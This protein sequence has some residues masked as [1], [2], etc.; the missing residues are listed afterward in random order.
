MQKRFLFLTLFFFTG[1]C[2]AQVSVKL[3]QPPPN[4]LSVTDIWKLTLINSGKNSIQITLNGTLEEAGDGII[5][6]GNSKPISLP[7]G[8]KRITY[9][10]IKTGNVNFKSG[11]WR[12]AFTRTGNAP[13]GD[14]TICIRVKS[15]SGEEI[16][17]DCINQKV[18]ISSPPT[19][20]SPVDG[21]SIPA[22]KPPTFTWLPPMPA[23]SGQMT[24]KLKIVE[25]I[26]NQS[27][28]TAIQRNSAWFE[29]SEIRTTMF[30]Y[31]VSARKFET[32][33]K[34]AWQIF[35]AQN[36]SSITS[37][38]IRR[39]DFQ[40][41]NNNLKSLIITT[42]DSTGSSGSSNTQL[43]A[44]GCQS[45]PQAA[46]ITNQIP[47]SKVANDFVQQII[48]VGLFSMKVLAAS[49]NSSALTGTGSILVPWLKTP[50]AVEF[51]N[52]KVNTVDELYD[53]N[54]ITQFDQTPDTWP[55]QWL[56]N[57]AGSFNWTTAKVKKL[58]HWLH[59]T[60]S[61]YP[62]VNKLVKDF[63]L[64]QM[65]QD[66]T[67]TP[68]KLPLGINNAD[69]YTIA[70]SEMKFEPTS[71]KLNCLAIFPVNEY[72]DSVGFK[73]S[74]IIFST[75]G[76]SLQSGKLGLIDDATFI[77]N[78]P[79]GD[80]YTVLIKKEQGASNGTFIS[81]DCEGFRELNIDLDVMFPRSWLKPVPDNGTDKAK[82]NI[83]TNI[84][85]WDDWI[86]AANLPKCT[87][88]GTQGM[89][90][91]VTSF[92]YDHSNLRNPDSLSFPANYPAGA[93]TGVSFTGFFIKEAK[94]KFP[95][96][97]KTSTQNITV[98]I[99]NMIINKQG[100]TGKVLAKDI[101]TFPNGNIS[102]LGASLDTL[103][104][105]IVC[106]SLTNAYLRGK[107]VLPV[108]EVNPLNS[109]PFKATF[110]ANN[111]FLF[112]IK[113]QGPITAKF[114][115]DA[116]LVLANTSTIN[117]SINN[118]TKFD[119]NLNG[120]FEWANINIGPVKNVKMAMDFQNVGLSYMDSTN[121]HNFTFNI[122][123]WSF[124]SPPK[125]LANFPVSI[126][127][128]KFK[129]KPKQGTE[130]I[131][132]GVSF[133]IIV[134][135][136]E[137]IG[138]TC[139]LSVIGAIEKDAV[140]GKFT[141]TFVGV[142]LD[143]IKVFANLSAVKLDGKI[144][145]Y[146]ADPVYG[147]G[148]MG[149]I[150]ATINSIK[151]EISSTLRMGS[152]NYNNGS[153]F[154]RYW[155]VDAKVILPK[156][157]GIPFMSGLAFYGFG[158]GVWRRMTVLN[159]PP[160]NP[161]D[162]ENAATTT[163]TTNSGA[164]FTPDKNIGLGLSVLAVIGTYPEPKAFNSDA[165]LTGEFSLAG[166]LNMIKFN[167]DFWCMA[168]LT[169]RSDATILGNAYV[170][171]VPPTKV[172]S[173]VANALIDKPSVTT[174]GIGNPNDRVNLAL[175]INGATSKWYFIC[176]TPSQPNNVKVLG[177]TAW[178]YTLVGNDIGQFIKHGFQPSTI[179]GLNSVGFAIPTV[180]TTIPSESSTGKGFA[181]GVGVNFSNDKSIDI[182]SLPR[183]EVYLKYG[184]GGG[185]EVNLSLLQ[186]PQNTVCGGTSPIG[187]RSWYA[188][189][190]VAAWFHGY[191]KVTVPTKD[192]FYCTVCC[193]TEP[194]TCDYTFADI[195]AGL[196]VQA[197]FPNPVW[198]NGSAL[199]SVNIGNGFIN[200]SNYVDVSY[201][202]QCMPAPLPTNQTYTQEDATQQ[203]GDMI[204][205][206]DTPP[207]PDRFDPGKKIGV[208]FGFTP[209]E[210]FDVQERQSDGSI[211][212]RTF[213]V[214]YYAA[215]T[216]LGPAPLNQPTTTPTSNVSQVSNQNF[217]TLNRFNQTA[218]STSTNQL[219]SQNRN[220]ASIIPLV[221][222]AGTNSLG[223]YEYYIQRNFVMTNYRNLEDTTR[224]KLT[225]KAELWAIQQGTTNVWEK[226]KSNSGNFITE[227]RIANF[228]SGVLQQTTIQPP[229]RNNYQNRL[230]S[231]NS[232]NNNSSSTN[233]QLNIH[234]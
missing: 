195:K 150:K 72:N 99:E 174:R 201:G 69:G 30:Q 233:N 162:V 206:I 18:E 153:N 229:S 44:S 142:N 87:I 219:S 88:S 168:E 10:D 164:T 227:T 146:S 19:L 151:T 35:A 41:G 161:S 110:A 171:Y 231:Q 71:A 102:G 183:G 193:G 76:P 40:S 222:S 184:A 176:G 158:V 163:N 131:R 113:P 187:F 126:N 191:V 160:L 134:N 156:T 2:F 125:F 179:A 48:K 16:G 65:V 17:S 94:I 46:T 12:E 129:M 200:W 100:L 13:S 68:L 139:A 80:S 98:N 84:V 67:D 112:T 104:L 207:S 194:G 49:G 230:T 34:Y 224:Y 86:I 198:I 141:P 60:L 62:S 117:F 218:V 170:Q 223:Q 130:V 148:F 20:I 214:R 28:E 8:M 155:Y 89:E 197:G 106:S 135:L 232:M 203:I 128:I 182:V 143:T 90:L 115:S 199:V 105:E 47:S 92:Y 59:N 167:F 31:P 234:R 188:L 172:F 185:F 123:T 15:E 210:A 165:T 217:Q 175:N 147:N 137:K 73:G 33:K 55:Q 82:C 37:S 9:D 178:E 108:S 136:D 180:Q 24:Y 57:G 56:I 124:A 22:E 127:Y 5:V 27:P 36:N 114:F 85:K 81:W 192:A 58:D 50:V 159:M 91:E 83:V 177:V 53:G 66:N 213:Q 169:K 45:V 211:V 119:I 145:F 38:E 79:N 205:N 101:F 29:K 166:G 32:E 189:G 54:V 221:R 4:Q 42:N 107:I 186:Y 96:N 109:L 204:I 6:E 216:S 95:D 144:A 149:S 51:K 26:G 61:N 103:K 133:S 111:G 116:K 39:F 215:L 14:Y 122:G 132:G 21:E 202:T 23:P 118:S 121:Y 152:T 63:D 25:T 181:F 74:D 75:G 52:I 212:N 154:F 43:P 77:G 225:L 173:L 140:T 220:T 70:I 120:N 228:S 93:D 78:V 208:M 209:N 226:A 157:S 97:F 196:Q 190:G 64:A 7:P 1:Y 138:G 11:K 3:Q